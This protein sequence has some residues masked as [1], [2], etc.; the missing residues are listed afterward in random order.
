MH[1]STF[2]SYLLFFFFAMFAVTSALPEPLDKKTGELL[3]RDGTDATH[4]EDGGDDERRFCRSGYITT[5]TKT[6]GI[7]GGAAQGIATASRAYWVRYI[8]EYYPSVN[9]HYHWCTNRN[10]DGLALLISISF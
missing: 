4:G 8:H 5:A 6:A 2:I 10:V 3:A 9:A 1:A 7:S